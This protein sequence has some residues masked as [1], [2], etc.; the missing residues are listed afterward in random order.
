MLEKNK[1]VKKCQTKF[2][3]NAKENEMSVI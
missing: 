3:D 2:K 1:Q